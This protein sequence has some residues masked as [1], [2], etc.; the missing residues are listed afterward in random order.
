MYGIINAICVLVYKMQMLQEYKLDKK[1][2][3]LFISEYT[4]QNW[5]NTKVTLGLYLQSQLHVIY[6]DYQRQETYYNPQSKHLYFK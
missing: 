1:G 2:G 5:G 4:E 6:I 3:V